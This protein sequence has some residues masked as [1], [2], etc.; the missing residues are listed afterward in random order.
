M[1]TVCL[2]CFAYIHVSAFAQHDGARNAVQFIADGKFG[3]VDATL[4][5]KK[6]FA[7]EAESRFV[8]MLSLLAQDKTDAARLEAKAAVELGLPFERLVVGPKELLGKLHQDPGFQS[9][10]AE[11]NVPLVIHGPMIGRVTDRSVSFWVRTQKPGDVSIELSD[12]DGFRKIEVIKTAAAEDCTGIITFSDL[13][14]DTTYQYKVGDLLLNGEVKTAPSFGPSKIK[15]AFGGGAGYVPEW[16]KM[17]D[18]IGAHSPDAMLML[19]DN[20]YIDQ[21]EHTLTQYYCY[22]RRQSRPEWKRLT[23]STPIYSIWD[24]HDFAVNDC[25]PGPEIDQPAWKPQVWKIFRQ[26]WINPGYGGGESQPGCWYDFTIGDVHFIMLDGRYYRDKKGK[27][28]LGPVQKKWVLKTLSESKGTFKILVSPVPFTPGIKPGSNDPW[29]GYPEEREKI[30]SH[31][32]DNN[33]EGVFLVAADRH[34]TDLRKIERPDSYTLYEFESSRLTNHHTHKVVKT[35]GLVWGYSKTC[36]FGLMEFDTTLKDP[37][38]TMT[39]NNIEG[40]ETNRFVL[41]LSQLKK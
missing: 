37:Q 22:Y 9:W 14:P 27:T 25:V 2:A 29:D 3:Q 19:G 34:R 17:W 11:F 4:K 23:G 30:F 16:E 20:V 32:G 36:S 28:M 38:V 12:G 8:K 13:S 21:P 7:G 15:V 18:T 24:D 41:K 40:E 35:P 31:I 6:P 5:N 33:I 10:Q 39:C 1:R 26:N